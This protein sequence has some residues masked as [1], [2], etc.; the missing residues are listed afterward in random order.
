MK[1][2]ELAAI[3]ARYAKRFHSATEGHHVGS[4]LGVWLLTALAAGSQPLR[5][6]VEAALEEALGLPV[7]EAFDAARN[8]LKHPNELV[9]SAAAAWTDP[10]YGTSAL[11]EWTDSLNQVADVGGIPSQEDADKWVFDKTLGLI[12]KFPADL[13]Q[14][15]A[16]VVLS[17]ALATKVTWTNPFTVVQ[18]EELDKWG[19]EHV[20]YTD[21]DHGHEGWLH[22]DEDGRVFGVHVARAKGG[23]KVFS[24]IGDEDLDAQ[25]VLSRA[26]D[27]VVDYFSDLTRPVNKINLFEFDLGRGHSWTVT[28]H[29]E[30]CLS[31]RS[32]EEYTVILPAWKATSRHDL[33]ENPSLGLEA[34]AVGLAQ[35][36]GLDAMSFAALQSAVASYSKRGFE[37]AAL[38]TLI[39]ARA[40]MPSMTEKTIRSCELTFARPYAVVAATEVNP[41]KDDPWG[42]VPL[43]SAWVSEATD[44]VDD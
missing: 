25:E 18:D 1:N 11:K 7:H 40:G 33:K 2:T 31:T 41:R 4:P 32:K 13:E 28:E 22:Q 36:A 30:L 14:I 6:D 10:A 19:V 34:A 43:F 42:G 9:A 44:A 3:I 5:T 29:T 16:V 39:V 27:I 38:S 17:T 35:K 8:L 23:M 21:C 12:D 24:V 37:A 20:L 26:H 15:E